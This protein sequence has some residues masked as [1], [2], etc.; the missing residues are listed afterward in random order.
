MSKKKSVPADGRLVVSISIWG[1]NKAPCH[2]STVHSS[3][4]MGKLYS[5]GLGRSWYFIFPDT[6]I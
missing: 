6:S 2:L 5:R 1:K 3:W 4:H